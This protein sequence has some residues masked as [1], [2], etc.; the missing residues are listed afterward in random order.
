VLFLISMVIL[1]IVQLSSNITE[2]NVK[3]DNQEKTEIKLITKNIEDYISD[4]KDNYWDAKHTEFGTYWVRIIFQKEFVIYQF[5]GQC[6]YW[7]FTYHFSSDADKIQL[8]WSYKTDCLL[9]MD[10]LNKSNGVKEHPKFGEPFCEY[11][12][13]NDSVIEVKYYFPE[14]TDKINQMEKDSIFP[15][16]FYL[17]QYE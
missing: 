13:K 17:Q 7:F 15:K 12:L 11:K 9:N 2:S 1:Y 10:F 3:I 14:W 6:I 16:Y 4:S 8:L 5:H